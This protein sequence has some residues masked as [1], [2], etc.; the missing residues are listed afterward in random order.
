MH[1]PGGTLGA[2]GHK[3]VKGGP[4]AHTATGY[5]L[6]LQV[7]PHL[8]GAYIQDPR[9]QTQPEEQSWGPRAHYTLTESFTLSRVGVNAQKQASG[10]SS[11][12]HTPRG[13]CQG[14][15]AHAHLEGVP[16]AH[17]GRTKTHA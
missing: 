10:R 14:P 6:G 9:A 7:H 4:A 17:T 1:K 3:P 15:N 13:R 12:R 8:Q 5:F 11:H 2:H 16:Q